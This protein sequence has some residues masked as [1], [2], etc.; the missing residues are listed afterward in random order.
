[1]SSGLEGLIE[2][3]R[4]RLLGQAS[5][6]I[7]DHY[8]VQS[9]FWLAKGFRSRTKEVWL[10]FAGGNLVMP[11]IARI[12]VNG[13]PVDYRAE[14]ARA[15]IMKWDQARAWEYRIRLRFPTELLTEGENS[16]LVSTH[17]LPGLVRIMGVD[18]LSA[19][20]NMSLA[21]IGVEVVG[22]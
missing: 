22:R 8:V 13:Y 14:P 21:A 18:E 2:F 15:K 17:M 3:G 19:M 9:G 10:D 1:M 12:R 16:V 7:Q 11:N 20:H 5:W 4:R 6:R